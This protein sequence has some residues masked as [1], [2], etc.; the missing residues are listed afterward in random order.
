VCAEASRRSTVGEYKGIGYRREAER[1]L[2][3][4][5]EA[6]WFERNGR[7]FLFTIKTDSKFIQPPQWIVT[8]HVDKALNFM[9]C[10]RGFKT[11]MEM[12]ELT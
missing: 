1:Q 2:V 7:Q 5:C 4:I 3:D 12:E 10:F 8:A 11:V 6:Q 9:H